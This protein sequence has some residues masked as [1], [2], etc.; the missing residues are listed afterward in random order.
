MEL[1]QLEAFAAVVHSGSFTQAGEERFL[2]QPAITRQ[3]AALER[4]FRTQLLNRSG[5]VATCT[6]AG[7]KLIEF[8][9]PLLRLAA[10]AKRAVADVNLGVAGRLSV[11]ASVTAA[12]YILPPLI[13]RYRERWPGVELSIH[14]GASAAVAAQVVAGTVDVGIVTGL[15]Y[16][17][18]F[19]VTRLAVYP[20]V[21][22]LYPGHRLAEQA[23]S[24]NW[25]LR[26]QD[27]AGAP[28]IL[29]ESGASLRTFVDRLL[30]TAGIQQQVTLELDN[31]EAI[32]HMIEAR[33]GISLLPLVTVHREVQDG[34]LVA[35][36]LTDAPAAE[37]ELVAIQMPG[38]YTPRAVEAFL[39]VLQDGL[40][41]TID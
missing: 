22:V 7:E 16:G 14:T 25:A 6:P 35:M 33:M 2:S 38:R 41:P 3:I 8:A 12:T 18:A 31:V 20:T 30:S 36:A 40:A 9:V 26:L 34:R 17:R 11:G 29:M 13:Q 23:P 27:L 28:L 39:G 21:V 10:D 5:R 19:K 37:R 1:R 32:K 24:G 4:E 15:Q